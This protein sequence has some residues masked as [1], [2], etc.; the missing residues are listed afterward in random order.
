MKTIDSLQ[1]YFVGYRV[2]SDAYCI[3]EVM[4]K[5]QSGSWAVSVASSGYH[6]HPVS[7]THCHTVQS[8]I[9]SMKNLINFSAKFK[10]VIVLLTSKRIG[11]RAMTVVVEK[12]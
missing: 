8:L 7:L 4:L 3:N 6:R 1:Q 10:N 11:V 2:L 12:L 5:L 9:Q